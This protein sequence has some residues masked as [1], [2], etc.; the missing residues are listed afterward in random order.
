MK[1]P[2]A[3]NLK[4]LDIV[5]RRQLKSPPSPKPHFMNATIQMG[6]GPRPSTGAMLM[7][8]PLVLG[9]LKNE[10]KSGNN[11]KKKKSSVHS[12]ESNH[13]NVTVPNTNMSPA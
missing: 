7:D 3:D 4:D 11:V 10:E 12:I 9:L 5:V 13:F 6:G 1:A 2:G 8:L